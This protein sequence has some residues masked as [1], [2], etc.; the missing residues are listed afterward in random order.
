MGPAPTHHRDPPKAPPGALLGLPDI[1]TESD[2]H[3]PEVLASAAAARCSCSSLCFSQGS[4]PNFLP[5]AFRAPGGS[6]PVTPHHPFR[7]PRLSGPPP[8]RVLPSPPPPSPVLPSPSSPPLL[9]SPLSPTRVRS[10][11]QNGKTNAAMEK[12]KKGTCGRT[13]FVW[14]QGEHAPDRRVRSTQGSGEPIGTVTRD[15]DSGENAA[16]QKSHKEVTT[17]TRQRGEHTESPAQPWVRSTRASRKYPR[18][19]TACACTET[20]SAA[21][22]VMKA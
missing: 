17:W 2:P 6:G 4:F 3:G 8:L 13:L 21:V 7:A 5:V 10:R 16:A 18:L 15:R 22:S 11:T 9:P 14:M 12:T 1:D 19:G 20:R